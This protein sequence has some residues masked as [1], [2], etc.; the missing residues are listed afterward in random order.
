MAAV[1]PKT[2]AEGGIS[3]KGWT[4]EF[5]LLVVVIRKLREGV[6][7]G[8]PFSSTPRAK[9]AGLSRPFSGMYL[10]Y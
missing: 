6:E 8:Q 3:P 9:A 5:T 10:S 1:W 2:T 4:S 7:G